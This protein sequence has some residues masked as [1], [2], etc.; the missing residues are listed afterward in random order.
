LRQT[1]NFLLPLSAISLYILS[2]FLRFLNNIFSAAAL[3]RR[4]N[5]KIVQKMGGQV[6]GRFSK[7]WDNIVIA[8][9]NKFAADFADSRLCMKL[10]TQKQA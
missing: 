9:R 5:S 6:I 4:Q 2:R 8:D 10:E 1:Q 7:L 3:A